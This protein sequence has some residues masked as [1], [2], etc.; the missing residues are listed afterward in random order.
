MC[1]ATLAR[2]PPQI[3]SNHTSVASL[4]NTSIALYHGTDDDDEQPLNDAA[5]EQRSSNR[6]RWWPLSR[7][8]EVS[9][10]EPR[11]VLQSERTFL[12]FIRFSLSL[13]FTAIGMTL[14]FRLQSAGKSDRDLPNFN[15]NAF[16][17][18]V[19]FILIFLAFATLI[20]A[21]LNYFRTVRRYS[22]HRIHT[23]GTNNT[24]LVVCITAVVVTL[25][26]VNISLIVERYLQDQ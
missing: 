26:A 5:E 24:T 16:N 22:Q 20:V 9:L 17:H 18:A 12:T 11:D 2:G 15:K 3:Y 8:L 14:G 1:A 23:Y 7:I 25:V 10:S 13:Y 21:G 6:R 4:S 19:S